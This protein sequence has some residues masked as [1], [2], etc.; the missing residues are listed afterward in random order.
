MLGRRYH[1]RDHRHCG[2][3]N[4]LL[5]EITPRHGARRRQQPRAKNSYPHESLRSL[6]ASRS[7]PFRNTSPPPS[8]GRQN[9]WPSEPVGNL[10][11]QRRLPDAKYP[12]QFA[13][14]LASQVFLCFVHKFLNA[15]FPHIQLADA[16]CDG[17]QILFQLHLL[18]LVPVRHCIIPFRRDP[19]VT[20]SSYRQRMMLSSS[21]D[22]LFLSICIFSRSAVL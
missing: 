18:L 12:Q 4:A 5:G 20:R 9:C 21:P 7:A 22:P 19:S 1:Y 6:P 8:P 2:I 16:F 11:D 10:L 14:A 13:S 15:L 3:G 17:R